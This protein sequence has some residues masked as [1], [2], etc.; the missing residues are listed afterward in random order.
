M[1]EA[2]EITEFRLAGCTFAQFVKA[3]ALIDQW[4]FRQ[5]GFISRRIAQCSTGAVIDLLVWD[6]AEN[7]TASMHRLM[8]ELADSQVHAM[9]D[10]ETVTWTVAP[11]RHAIG[12]PSANAV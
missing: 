12:I 9:V 1:S 11:V 2:I 3:N 7:A 5:P 8:D 10:Q 4:L 6:S